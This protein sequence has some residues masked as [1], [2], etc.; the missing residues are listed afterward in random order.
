M[1]I[2][3][4]CNQVKNKTFEHSPEIL[5]G[6]GITGMLSSTILAVKATPKVYTMIEKEK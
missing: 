4:I 6:I 5:L 2:M 3:D 1:K